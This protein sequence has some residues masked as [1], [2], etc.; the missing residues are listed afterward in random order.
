MAYYGFYVPNIVELAERRGQIT[1]EDVA[2]KFSIPRDRA[3]SIVSYMTR[4][5]NNPQNPGSYLVRVS[6]RGK[7]RKGVYARGIRMCAGATSVLG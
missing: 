3:Q 5:S 1:V 2:A 7:G 6:R 4:G